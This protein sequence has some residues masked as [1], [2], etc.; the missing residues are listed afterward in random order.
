MST[1]TSGSRDLARRWLTALAQ[2]DFEAW[3]LLVAEDVRMRF[4]FAPPGIPDCCEGRA[5]CQTV[6]QA[7]FAGIVSFAWQELQLHPAEDSE[8]VFATARSSVV[9]KTGKRYRNEYCFMMRF[10]DGKLAEYR[11]YFNPLP[12][13]E[14]FAPGS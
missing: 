6:L 10:R 4:P 12:A 5:A 2:A 9:L 1:P 14:A 7:F 8:L 13:I 11:E 3:P